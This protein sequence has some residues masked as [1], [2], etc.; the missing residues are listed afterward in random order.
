MS[1]KGEPAQLQVVPADVTLKPGGAASLKAF[2]YDE[3]GK[4]L[5]ETKVS[6]SR[7]ETSVW[8]WTSPTCRSSRRTSSADAS[9]RASR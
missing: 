9:R 3:N 6:W 1:K 8:R 7:G 2:A 4:R 5:G